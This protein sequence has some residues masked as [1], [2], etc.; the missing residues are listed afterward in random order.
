[1]RRSTKYWTGRGGVV[2]PDDPIETIR[3]VARAYDIRWLVLER[4]ATVEALRP[5]LD[6]GRSPA[7]IGPRPSRSRRPT[8]VDRPGALSGLHRV[9][10][11]VRVSR[12]DPSRSLAVGRRHLRRRAR[13]S[14]PGSPRRSTSRSP[15]TR[16][17]TSASRATSSRAAASSPTRSGATRRRRSCS[18]GRR[19]RSGCRLPSF[20]AAIPMALFGATFA[21][22]PGVRRRHRRHR[23]GARVASRRGRRRRAW[24]VDDSGPHPGHRHRPHDRDLPPAPAP[25]APCPIRRCRSRCSPWRRAC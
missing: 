20:L 23:P 13:R 17:T 6:R 14:A 12:R 21:V 1:M 22:V 5:V 18:R 7:W 4:G 16:P 10:D 9:D 8:T 24:P 3:D 2:S 11:A 25:L 15:R 19:S